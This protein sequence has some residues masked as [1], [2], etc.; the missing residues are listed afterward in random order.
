MANQQTWLLIA[1]LSMFTIL[2]PKSCTEAV[3]LPRPPSS[4]LQAYSRHNHQDPGSP[5][6][7]PDNSLSLVIVT[8]SELPK[9]IPPPTQPLAHSSTPQYHEVDQQVP[10]LPQFKLLWVTRQM[11]TN[12]LALRHTN[13]N[14]PSAV[15]TH[16]NTAQRTDLLPNMV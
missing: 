3:V 9:Q 2:G 16:K 10:A 4:E 13:L 14:T 7:F 5:S 11:D 12:S 1:A 15:I 6:S 8:S